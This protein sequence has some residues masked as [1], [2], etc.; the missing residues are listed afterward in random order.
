V[1][2]PDGTGRT[3]K[4]GEISV[5]FMEWDFLVSKSRLCDVNFYAEIGKTTAR[6][7]ES[8]KN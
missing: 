8:P 1:V 2:P 6:C 7:G 5:L 3:E 4:G